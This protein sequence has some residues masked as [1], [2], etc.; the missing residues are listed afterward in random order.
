M[1]ILIRDLNFS[2]DDLSIFLTG[3][4]NASGAKQKDGP[5]IPKNVGRGRTVSIV[6]RDDTYEILLGKGKR[7]RQRETVQ[8]KTLIATILKHPALNTCSSNLSTHTTTTITTSATMTKTYVPD[9]YDCSVC[10]SS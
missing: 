2:G 8:C 10:R 7:E 3:G 6:T 5:E 1:F 4:V 9:A